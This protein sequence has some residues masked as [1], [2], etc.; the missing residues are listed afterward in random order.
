MFA[1]LSVVVGF[2]KEVLWNIRLRCV[3]VNVALMEVSIK[4]ATNALDLIP[5]SPHS[6]AVV[7]EKASSAPLV[8]AYMASPLY[9][10]CTLM[11]EI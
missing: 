9:P 10:V 5:R 1:T 3:A 8:D 11:E 2:F 6:L 7:L 4:P